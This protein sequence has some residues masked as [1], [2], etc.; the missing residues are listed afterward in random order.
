MYVTK[1]L[2]RKTSL[3]SLVSSVFHKWF[4][5]LFLIASRHNQFILELI[6]TRTP[7]TSIVSKGKKKE[8]TNDYTIQMRIFKDMKSAGYKCQWSVW[9]IWKGYEVIWQK[10]K[11]R[12]KPTGRERERKKFK[13]GCRINCYPFISSASF[14]MA[15]VV[16]VASYSYVIKVFPWR[17]FFH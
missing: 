9:F 6:W 8:K 12:P 10:K 2:E 1:H 5:F 11:W 13:R 14:I 3:F 16:W 15:I 17:C 4:S 7:S